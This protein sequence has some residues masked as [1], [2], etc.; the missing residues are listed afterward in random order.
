MTCGKIAFEAY[1]EDRGGVN[2]LGN[3]TPE[4]EELP[5]E[6]QHGWEVGASA[7]ATYEINRLIE[8]GKLVLGK[9]ES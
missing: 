5:K 7:A 1:N 8:K 9:D 2:H 3:K 4:W 6:V